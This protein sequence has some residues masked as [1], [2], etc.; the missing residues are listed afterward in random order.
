[1]GS[2]NAAFVQRYFG[3]EGLFRKISSQW[4]FCFDLSMNPDQTAP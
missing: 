3:F 2:P 4:I 1:M